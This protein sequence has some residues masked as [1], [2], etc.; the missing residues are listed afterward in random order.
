MHKDKLIKQIPNAITATRIVGSVALAATAS[1]IGF[2]PS[3]LALASLLITDLIDGVLARKLDAKS[4]LGAKL[5]AIADKL[6]AG[7]LLITIISLG[8]SFSIALFLPL[9]FEISIGA[10]NLTKHLKGLEPKT[11]LKGKIKTWFLS[12]LLVSA[13]AQIKVPELSNIVNFLLATTLGTQ[14]IT[15]M[16]YIDQEEEII[17]DEK[18]YNKISEI[19]EK[20]KDNKEKE[21]EKT[22]EPKKYTKED[23]LELRNTYIKEENKYENTLEETTKTLKK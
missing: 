15:F 9:T 12:G 20:I 2:L 21:V 6:F 23:Y 8:S 4:E 1:M 17:K 3:T 13:Y 22:K 19:K 14:L 16:G 11:I 18:I 5:D 7:V 10:L